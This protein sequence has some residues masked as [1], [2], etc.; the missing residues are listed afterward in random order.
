MSNLQDVKDRIA[1]GYRGELTYSFRSGDYIITTWLD[2]AE[3]ID[4][5][6]HKFPRG[7]HDPNTLKNTV[8]GTNYPNELKTS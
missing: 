7:V 2:G 6:T 8:Y 3:D 5:K 4:T 1:R